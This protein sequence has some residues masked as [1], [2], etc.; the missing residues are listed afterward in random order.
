M[1]AP[2][3]EER[4]PLRC[5]LCG[6]PSRHEDDLYK[7]RLP[8]EWTFEHLYAWRVHGATVRELVRDGVSLVKLCSRCRVEIDETVDVDGEEKER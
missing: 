2:V 7:L 1:R 6:R 4:V 8:E 3:F 5:S